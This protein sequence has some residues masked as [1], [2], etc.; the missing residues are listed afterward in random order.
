MKVNIPFLKVRKRYTNFMPL[1]LDDVLRETLAASADHPCYVEFVDDSRQYYLFLREGQLYCAAKI[2]DET[3]SDTMIKDFFVT[4]GQMAHPQVTAYEVN[5]KILHSLLVLFQKKPSV[6][7]LTSLVDLDEVLD[8]IEADGRSCVVCARQDSF[9]ALLRYE[10]GRVTALCHEE[11]L[12]RPKEGNFREDFLVKIYTLSAERPLTITIFEDLMVTYAKDAKKLDGDIEGSIADIYL[13][14]PPIVSLEFK[15]KEVG[16]WVLDKPVLNI[17]RTAE[18]DIQID[19]LAVSRLHAVIEREKGEYYVRDC[20]SLNGTI[21]NGKRIARER[22]SNGSEI[23]IGKHKVV[24]RAHGARSTFITPDIAPFDQ[25][26]VLAPGQR[27]LP[28]FRKEARHSPRLIERTS[29][30]DLVIEL[31]K[32]T[33]VI[34]A[35]DDADIAVDGFFVAKYHA[36]ISHENGGY[37]IRHVGGLRKV[38]VGGRTIKEQMLKNNDEIRIAKKEFVFQQ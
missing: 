17:G 32:N 9:L 19:N 18:N 31:D 4:T 35:G 34:G 3:F 8:R 10:K 22:L 25:T 36:E 27:V 21:L 6:Q 11:S 28:A 24:F 20:D 2:A 16:H 33:F 37:V 30:G 29:E 7:V 14:K 38:S 12:V 15:G 23:T 1:E 13:S 26:V 5:T